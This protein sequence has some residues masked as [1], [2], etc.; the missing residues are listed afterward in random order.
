MEDIHKLDNEIYKLNFYNNYMKSKIVLFFG[1]ISVLSFMFFNQSAISSAVGKCNHAPPRVVFDPVNQT[2][3]PGEILTYGITITNLN[4]AYC[5][6][7]NFNISDVNPGAG[8]VSSTTDQ[9]ILICNGCNATF[10]YELQ[11][12]VNTVHG[13]YG[14]YVIVFEE[15]QQSSHVTAALGYYSVP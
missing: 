6:T 9:L 12:P 3:Q 14:T 10:E 13:S 15:G 11:S 8:W 7:A 5:K 2:G 1:V 4:T